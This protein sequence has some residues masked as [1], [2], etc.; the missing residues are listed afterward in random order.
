MTR[1][2]RACITAVTMS[3]NGS[4]LARIKLQRARDVTMP[5]VR[6]TTPRREADLDALIEAAIDAAASGQL[7]QI[8]LASLQP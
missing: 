2:S 1:R 3:G 8:S 4:T 5:V 6:F 7:V